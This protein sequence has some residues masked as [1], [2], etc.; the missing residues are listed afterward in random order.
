MKN[1]DLVILAGGK[2]TR[3]KKYLH[4]KPKPMVKFNEIYFLQYLINI[5]SKYPINKIFIL[6]GYK[7]DIIFKNFHNKT[8]NFTKVVCVKEKKLMGTGGALLSLKKKKIKDFILINGDTVFDID[9]ADFIKSFKKKKLGSVA[10]APNS[11]NIN[12]YKLNNLEI[13]N[14]ILCYK[15]NSKLMNG[16]VYFF[17]RRILNLIP[18]KPCSLEEDVF[19]NIIKK[20]LL[21]G[22]IYKNFFLDI[23]TPKYFNVSAKRL[24]DYFSRPAAFLDRDGVIN[25]DSGYVYKKKDF[26]FRKGVIKGLKYLIKKKYYIFIVTNQAG[27]AKGIYNENDFKKL[28]LYLKRNLSKKNIYFNDVQYCPYHPK[29]KIKIYRKKSSL[30]K[31]G[32]QMVK[33]ILKIWLVNKRKSF[34]IGDKNSDKYCAK[35]SKLLFFFSENNFYKQIINNLRKN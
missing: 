22:K 34:M 23:G 11:K 31:P 15:K 24:K 25:H 16:G 1:L 30:R 9:L 6:V 27:I 7:S 33:N 28:H 4:N 12:N 29:G 3:I 10:L 2:G 32:N 26:R 18:N 8:F 35:K 19:P 17:K 14:N 13:K 20:K 5:F 21:T